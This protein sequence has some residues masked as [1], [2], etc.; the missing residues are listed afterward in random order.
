MSRFSVKRNFL[1][2]LVVVLLAVTGAWAQTGTTSL[3]GTV[4]DPGGAS[5]PNATV[6]VTSASIGVTLT[7]K[8]DRDGVYQFLEMRPATYELT[9]TAAGFATVKQ[10]DLQLLVATPATNNIVLRVASVATAVEVSATALTLNTTDA[11]L[12]SAFDSK[13]IEALPAE[14]RDPYGILSAQPGVVTIADRDQVDLGQD[15]RG[16]AVNGARS[17]Q[18]NLTLDGVDNNDQLKGL[19]FTGA[20]RATLDSI[21]EFRVTTT[22]AGA[23]QGRSSGAQV[24]LVTKSGTND[25]HGAAY[26][27]NRPKN[28][29][30]NDWFNK[31]SELQ[32]G[33]PNKPP[34]LL[35]NTFGASFGGPI[36]KD[37]LFYFLAYEGQRTRENS[38]VLRAVPSTLLRQGIIE[39]RCADPTQCPGGTQVLQGMDPSG[40]PINVTV[41]VPAGLNALGTTQIASMD[42]NCS[43]NGT[44]PWGP[45]VDP[46]VIATLNQYP[47]PNTNQ[48]GYGYNFQAFTFSS[49]AP[50][51]LDTYVA[52][53]DYNL[54]PSGTQR[55][56]ARLGLQ[57]D[58]FNGAQWFP[59]QPPSTVR[60]NN[61]K[62]VVTGYAWAVSPAKVNNLHYGFIRQ[63]VGDNGSSQQQFV[64]LR[65]LSTP[66]SDTRSTN[67]VVPVH[68]LT[69]DFSWT[70]GRHTLQFGGNWRLINNL[71]SSNAQSFSD[72]ITNTGFLPTTGFAGKSTSLD[73]HCDPTINP[74]CTWSFPAVD[75]G[76]RNAYDFPM[77]ALAG[78]ITEADA[79][80][81]RDKN[82]NT[83]ASPTSPGALVKRHFRANEFETYLQDAWRIKS[84]LTLTYGLRY[85]LLQPPYEVNGNQV[86][87]NLSLDQF[88][89]TRVKDM[90]LGQSFAPN[91]Q[92]DLAG[93]ANG[94]KPYWAWD[95]KNL[96]PRLS[97]AWSPG[98]K[99]GLLG[100]LF[101]G[102]GKSSL[103]IGAGVYYDHFGEGIVNTFDKNGSF[104][105]TTFIADAPGT[106]SVDTAPRY[107]AISA[108]PTIITPPG[109]SGPFPIQP[110]T[111]DQLGGFA[112]YWGLDDKL[113]TPYSYAFDLSFS[114]EL[115]GGFVLEAAYVGRLGR[116][117]LQEKD[118]AQPENLVDPKSKL[119]Y[120][121]ALTALA[122]VYRQLNP[123]GSL[124]VP[125][126]SFNPSMVS[127]AVVQYWADILQPLQGPNPGNGGLGGAYQIGPNSPNGSCGSL[128]STTV[129]VVAAYDL[130][131]SGS[132]NETTP[133]FF[134]DLFGIPDANNV[135]NCGTPGFPSC[136]PNLFPINGQFSF[137]QSQ[138]ASL[139][140]WVSGG[141]SNYNA[142]Q[143]MLR[144]S[145]TH[146][147]S[148][149]FNYTYS[150]SI[151]FTSDA[152]RVNL[153]EGYG[154][155]GGQIINAFEP[156]LARGVSDFDMTHQINTTWLYELP[157]G[158]NKKWGSGWN[159]GLDAIAGGWSWSGL[160]KWTSGLPFIVQNGFDFPTNWELNGFA[161]LQ[162]AA[163]KTGVFNDCDGDPNMFA[164][165]AASTGVCTQPNGIGNFI[166]GPTGNDGHWRFP[167]PGEAGSRNN[168]RGPGYFGID[169]GLRKT[170]GLTE[171]TKLSFSWQVY[172]LTNSVRF[173]AA[174]GAVNNTFLDSAGSFGKYSNTLT[175]PRVM[176]F[177]LR[178]SF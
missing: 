86:A 174:N 30:A 116:R 132:F 147:L 149:N 73:P 16:G 102:P 157:F 145:A 64:F 2:S 55:L 6:T 92:L 45:G 104:G 88:F 169:M 65:G 23:D 120:F 44:C 62:G 90:A 25:I 1:V 34:S 89:N 18:S 166:L 150:K 109:P 59:G 134:L 103:R 122:Q 69:D 87:P 158:R 48:L 144:H 91:F 97:L 70:K 143:L 4:T 154:F 32:S 159:R 13:L 53:F 49:P 56:F 99:D 24:S 153:F 123:D 5:V 140:S 161:V 40:N 75:S 12:G 81:Q 60:T 101:G 127:P 52:K 29:V 50:N 76:S 66:V 110:P 114:R 121:Q 170:W 41:N 130:F 93:Q 107:T 118:L 82:G 61:S 35:R 78:I 148:W 171:R 100:S 14:G 84:N 36:K 11:T 133:L 7:T 108:I 129:P 167:F 95:Y 126:Q 156:Q 80:Y 139:Y 58:H 124:K 9:I 164:G 42:P 151:D 46:N 138:F 152:E 96:A 22:N 136:N 19:A 83:V 105:L 128:N 71:R 137:Y 119:S 117:L 168:L 160:G 173:D 17:D 72:A 21:E 68:N 94:R 27:Y 51:K 79:F 77:A 85:S 26:E 28:L 33:R 31:H 177:A 131:C 63:G 135:A 112:I 165:L 37:R 162:G 20:L 74:Q 57:N 39:Y 163:P 43:G 155:G 125:T 146:G 67:V 172:N 47:Q 176:E 142:L 15:S 106:V 10:H 98:Y 54:T 178:L 8:T 3:R 111:S 38:Q 175:R 113:K 141:R 115:K